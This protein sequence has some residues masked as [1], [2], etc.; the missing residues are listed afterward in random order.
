MPTC[1]RWSNS[2]AELSSG[3]VVDQRRGGGQQGAGGREAHV[4]ERPQPV[5]V[6]VDELIKGGAARPVTGADIV[7]A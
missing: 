3:S 4:V 7:R 6:V 1:S 5:L 2:L